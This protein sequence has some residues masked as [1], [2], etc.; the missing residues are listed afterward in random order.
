M[1]NDME[2]LLYLIADSESIA[3]DDELSHLI[4]IEVDSELSETELEWVSAARKERFE[5]FKQFLKD[6]GIE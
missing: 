1:N 6:K 3:H 4:Q 2:K 5:N